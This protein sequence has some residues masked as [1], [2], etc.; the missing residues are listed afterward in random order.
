MLD[1][2]VLIYAVTE[3]RNQVAGGS[4]AWIM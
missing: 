4:E 1:L 2:R 3:L